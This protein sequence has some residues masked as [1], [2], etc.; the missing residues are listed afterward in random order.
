MLTSTLT[1]ELNLLHA[2]FCSALADPTRLLL[3]YSLAEKPCNVS[4]LTQLLSLPQP[5]ISRHLKILRDRGL[6]EATRQ[7]TTVQYSLTN[8]RIIDALDILRSVMRDL[9]EHRA[10]LVENA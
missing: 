3:L 9:I 1:Q 10:S 8:P 5:M 7:G 6:V 2:D 4:E